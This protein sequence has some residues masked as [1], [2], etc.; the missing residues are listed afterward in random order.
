M[1]RLS[2]SNRLANN[3]TRPLKK[4]RKGG[5]ESYTNAA[6]NVR[7]SYKR[8]VIKELS[9]ARTLASSHLLAVA[10]LP[11]NVLSTRW[12]EGKNQPMDEDYIEKLHRSFLNRGFGRLDKRIT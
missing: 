10:K 2:T 6:P 3:K 11:L 4:Q 1:K 7:D 12:S 8:I 9:S 5:D